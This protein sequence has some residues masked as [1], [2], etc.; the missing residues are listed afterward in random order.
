MRAR[1]RLRYLVVAGLLPVFVLAVALAG[2][3]AVAGLGRSGPPTASAVAEPSGS[4]VSGAAPSGGLDGGVGT[5]G[6]FSP[7]AGG[8]QPGAGGG[9]QPG[10]S[11]GGQPGA[12]GGG[13]PGTS[14]GAQPGTSGGG[15]PGMGG[16]GQPGAG[17][18]GQPGTG[19]G[20]QPGTSG[21]GQPG[22]GGG[23]QP[24]TS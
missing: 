7:M 2:H 17:G 11:G 3:A 15:Q 4:T 8:G 21:G 12:G 22:A 19:G 20:G 23:G 5:D 9:G 24:G 6:P 10:T 1:I 16:G 18:G 14:G 13:Q